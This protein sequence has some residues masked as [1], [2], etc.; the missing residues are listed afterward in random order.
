MVFSSQVFLFYFLP[1]ALLGYYALPQRARNAYF[2]LISYAFYGWANPWFVLLMLGST[3]LDWFCGV[4]LDS[5]KASARSRKGAVTTSVVANLSLLGFFKYFMFG[6]ENVNRLVEIFGAD[7]LPTLEILLPVG[8]SFYTFQSMSYT[9]DLYRGKAKRAE[10]FIDF[11]C[12]VSMF[13]QLV[14][15]PIVRYSEIATQLKDRPQRGELFRGGTIYFMVGLAKK[16]LLANSLGEISDL[17]LTTGPTPAHVAWFGTC[18]HA[19]QYYFDFSGYSDM[20][21]GLGMMFGFT[22]PVNFRAPYRS[23]NMTEM[24]TRWH[25]SLSG[26]LRDYLYIPLGGNRH[27]KLLTYRNLFLTMLLGGLWHGAEWTFLVW[28]ACHG[29]LLLYERMSGDNSL[30]ARLPRPL[31]RLRSFLT[32]AI[33]FLLFPAADLEAAWTMFLSL[34]IGVSASDGSAAAGAVLAG[35]VYQ[36]LYVGVVLLSVAITWW[37]PMNYIERVRSSAPLT[38]LTLVLFLCSIVAMLSQASNP[39]LYF[40]F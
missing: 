19:F 22:L 26:W 21:I 11:A 2:T 25:I 7:S 29:L 31:C 5:P 13:P 6:Q 33:L 14:A 35:R 3:V 37:A 23:L 27:G 24:W 32:F 1:L 20:A 10:S 40:R 16:V 15:G 38:A 9:I 39:F 12:Y 34:F 30:Y 4:V 28:G 8:I 36:P 18:A 17:V